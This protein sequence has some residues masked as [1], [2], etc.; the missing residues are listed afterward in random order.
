MEEKLTQILI[1]ILLREPFFGHLAAKLLRESREDVEE[2]GLVLQSDG[3]IVLGVNP[4]FWRLADL[5][6]SGR[7]GAIKHELLH[8][9]LLHPFRKRE[10]A[11]A[12][13]YTIAADLVVN[14]YLSADQLRPDQI[15][16]DR[17]HSVA[18][19][20]NR[21]LGYYYRKLEA[22]L[23]GA[24]KL[25]KPDQ[26]QI[27]QWSDPSHPAQQQ[28]QFWA[29]AMDTLDLE[30]K[31]A[32]ASI[33]QHQIKGLV[34]KEVTASFYRLDEPLRELIF[35][36]LGEQAAKVD[37]KRVLRMFATNSRKMLLKDTI[38]RPSKRYGTVPGVK[39]RRHQKLMIALDTSGSLPP[40]MLS[41]FLREIHQLWRTGA[42]MTIVECDD[43]IHNQYPY[44]GQKVLD[45][46]G[47]GST[48]FDPPIQLANDLRLDGLI[49]LTD[50]FGPIPEVAPRMPML[51]LISHQ[52]IRPDSRTWS[53]LPG[54]VVKM[55]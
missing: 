39:I 41:A 7:Y 24:Q 53:R 17:L 25:S 51:W 20:P 10:F 1:E 23:A 35:R 5:D 49:Y 54:R 34:E 4:A 16:L 43:Q 31:E 47:R 44:R 45:V 28:H 12:E 29:D 11:Q 19:E 6:E 42:E 52:G 9:A 50:G 33:W 36:R 15:R 13:L 32:L 40:A 48:A 18:W 55:S 14:Q 30:Q 27:G 3:T 22:A 26:E 38:R 37:W 2:T 46:A 21:S 8:L